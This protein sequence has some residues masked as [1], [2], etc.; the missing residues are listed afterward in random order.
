MTHQ[1]VK[2][3]LLFS[4]AHDGENAEFRFTCKACNGTGASHRGPCTNCSA[5]GHTG[6]WRGK[7][8]AKVFEQV[9]TA[10]SI[11]TAFGRLIKGNPAHRLEKV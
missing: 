2:S 5:T 11:G 9:R 7:V 3:S 10:R 1:R 4:L 8:P 6:T